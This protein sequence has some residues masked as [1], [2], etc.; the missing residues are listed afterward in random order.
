MLTEGRGLGLGLDLHL[1][2]PQLGESP[3][4]RASSHFYLAV[5]TH[6]AGAGTQNDEEGGTG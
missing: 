2:G 4:Q 6:R 5:E 1:A 3:H